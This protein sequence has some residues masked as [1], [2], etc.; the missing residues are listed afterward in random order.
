MTGWRIGFA[1]APIPVAKAMSNLQD[2][3][4]SNP[5]SFAQKGAVAAYKLPQDAVEAMRA[6][7]EARRDLIVGLLRQIPGVQIAEPGG[8][9]Y[10]FANFQAHLKPGESDLDLASYLLEEAR[11]AT[12]PG[13]VFEGPGHLRLSY[14]ARRNYLERGVARIAEALGMRKG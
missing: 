2:Q 1:A 5:N 14:A 4:T 8:A 10:A 13:S 7:F 9:F 3:V 11:V 12:V 6:E